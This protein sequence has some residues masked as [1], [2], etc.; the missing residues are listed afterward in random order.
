QGCDRRVNMKQVEALAAQQS[1]EREERAQMPE[2]V[3][4]SGQRHGLDAKTFA[5]DL[6][7]QRS[8]A[9]DADDLMT[10]LTQ[11]FHQ[12]KK[13]ME[14]REVDGAKLR[15]LHQPRAATAVLVAAAIRSMVA[16]SR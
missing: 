7:Q 3:I 4:A 6:C 5:A 8:F 15:D 1:N 14:K 16:S 2:R 9:G 11:A 12:G 13:K 10:G